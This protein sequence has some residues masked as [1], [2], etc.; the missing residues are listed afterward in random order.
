MWRRAS[1]RN[2]WSSTRAALE[3]LHR[4]FGQRDEVALGGVQHVRD[5][6]AV[7]V[8]RERQVALDP[9]ALGLDP[10]PLAAVVDARLLVLPDLLGRH[11]LIIASRRT[12]ASPSSCD[13]SGR[14]RRCA[15]APSC[16]GA[17][18]AL[19]CRPRSAFGPRRRRTWPAVARGSERATA[20]SGTTRFARRADAASVPLTST[21]QP[22]WQADAERERAAR[23]HAAAR[24]AGRRAAPARRPAAAASC[25]RQG[26]R[27]GTGCT[28]LKRSTRLLLVSATYTLPRA[29]DR[30][31]RRLGEVAQARC[32]GCPTWRGSARLGRTPARGC[33]RCPARTRCRRRRQPRRRRVEAARRAPPREPHS[34]STFAVRVELDDAVVA[35]VGDVDVFARR[36][37][38]WRRPRGGR[39]APGPLPAAPLPPPAPQRASNVPSGAV[40]EHAVVTGVGHVRAPR[41]R[42]HGDSR[43]RR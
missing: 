13:P 18:R 40:D 10:D 16:C 8:P 37:A 14:R 35:L 19:R 27:S 24:A 20:T 29:V 42:R 25:P 23:E 4:R 6:A 39:S 26:S 34:R 41:V 30:D 38:D 21:L 2:G 12:C 15:R 28:G 33:F 1:V 7:A 32:R 22:R 11:P 36:R 9:L 43:R 31:R 5:A 17:V 3:R